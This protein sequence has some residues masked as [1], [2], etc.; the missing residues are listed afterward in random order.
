[1][2]SLLQKWSWFMAGSIFVIMN[3]SGGMK[4]VTI[5]QNF[6]LMKNA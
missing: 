3:D 4:G 5:C 2:D 1:M 6:S